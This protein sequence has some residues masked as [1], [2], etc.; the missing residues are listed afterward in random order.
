MEIL[1]NHSFIYFNIYLTV[2]GFRWA[3]QSLLWHAV[4]FFLIFIY[5]AALGLN[6]QQVGSF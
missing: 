6:L 2:L 4:F 1:H 3:L 5:F